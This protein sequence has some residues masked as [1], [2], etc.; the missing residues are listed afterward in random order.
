VITRKFALT[1]GGR[2]YVAIALSFVAL[3]GLALFGSNAISNLLRERKFEEL[4]HLT[5]SAYAIVADFHTRAQR[6]EM[7]EPDAKARAADALRAIRYAGSEYVF[8]HGYDAVTVMH[9][10]NPAMQGKD[11]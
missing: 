4:K 1:V 3:I 8:I 10:I 2:F 9:P 6:G 7:S 11:Q 5:E